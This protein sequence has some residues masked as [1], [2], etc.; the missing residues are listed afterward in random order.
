MTEILSGQA[1]AVQQGSDYNYASG[2]NNTVVPI[3]NQL[4]S[5]RINN[6][7]VLFRTRSFPSITEGDHIVVAGKDKNGTFQATALKNLTTGAGYYMPNGGPIALAVVAILM[8]LLVA[9]GFFIG[10]LV[11]WG[12]AAWIIFK[13]LEYKKAN[14]MVKAFTG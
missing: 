6:R 9:S 14:D 5:L 4:F 10:G 1:N 2:A 8:G 12:L 13:V 11:L 3:K 7:A